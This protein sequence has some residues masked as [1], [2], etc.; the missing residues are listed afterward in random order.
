M[1]DWIVEPCYLVVMVKLGK[2]VDGFSF[3]VFNA[4]CNVII[5]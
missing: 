3:D 5:Y 1:F 2:C 4:K